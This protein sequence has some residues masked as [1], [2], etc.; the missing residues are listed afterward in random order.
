MHQQTT[1]KSSTQPLFPLN[2]IQHQFINSKLNKTPRPA[3]RK[4]STLQYTK[5]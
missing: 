1:E 4:T 2:N 3:L 5:Q